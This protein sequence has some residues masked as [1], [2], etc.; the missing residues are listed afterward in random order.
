MQGEFD[1]GQQGLMSMEDPRLQQLREPLYTRL[2]NDGT[3]FG[4]DVKSG[5]PFRPGVKL[6]KDG[7][8]E[9]IG[10]RGR[11]ETELGRG[12]LGA[13]TSMETERL[14]AY[15]PVKGLYTMGTDRR[16]VLLIGLRAKTI[17]NLPNAEVV[18]GRRVGLLENV[19]VIVFMRS[20]MT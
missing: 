15:I 6:Q 3:L 20:K 4:A 16:D 5:A 14:S 11:V 1:P 19:R 7:G 2:G 17:L 8:T 18:T 13:T 9:K 12:S 10:T